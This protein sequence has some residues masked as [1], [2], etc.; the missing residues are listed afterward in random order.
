L[1]IGFLIS[2]SFKNETSLEHRFSDFNLIK[3]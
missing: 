1:S 2:S 3:K